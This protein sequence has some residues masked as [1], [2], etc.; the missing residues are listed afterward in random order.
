VNVADILGF[1]VSPKSVYVLNVNLLIGINPK[2]DSAMIEVYEKTCTKCKK[3]K[4]IDQFR[5]TNLKKSGYLSWCRSCEAI[6]RKIYY[7]NNQKE[8]LEFDRNHRIA[9]WTEPKGKKIIIK[10]V[11]K[12]PMPNDLKCEICNKISKR[13][14][15]HHWDNDNCSLGI[16]VCHACHQGCTFTEKN[17]DKKY[18]ELKETITKSYNPD[19]SNIPMS[20]RQ[21]RNQLEN[22]NNLILL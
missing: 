18:K 22:K 8:L 5:A 17:L 6:Q 20:F 16:W 10:G 12:R 11:A 15:Y 9:T 3:S 1:L 21:Y 4:P 2:K 13:L 7:R 19:L 14:S